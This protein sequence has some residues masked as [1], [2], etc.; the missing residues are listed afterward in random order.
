MAVSVV[1]GWDSWK[2]PAG[3]P[4]EPKNVCICF[5]TWSREQSS[6][7][8]SLDLWKLGKVQPDGPDTGMQSSFSPLSWWNKTRAD[9]SY[10]PWNEAYKHFIFLI[11]VVVDVLTGKQAKWATLFCWKIHGKM[12]LFK[13]LFLLCC[14]LSACRWEIMITSYPHLVSSFYVSVDFSFNV[15]FPSIFAVLHQKS[16]E[17]SWFT[18]DTW[19]HLTEEKSMQS[20]IDSCR[21]MSPPSVSA[22]SVFAL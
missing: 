11:S 17:T 13:T 14:M 18:F 6:T 5:R 10:L 3:S 16:I 19:G 12:I 20:S 7:A 15:S 4:Q 2:E 9:S 22:Q 8:Y 1:G 21:L